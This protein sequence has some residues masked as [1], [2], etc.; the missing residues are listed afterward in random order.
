MSPVDLPSALDAAGDALKAAGESAIVL[1][2]F[3]FDDG[4]HLFT[5]RLDPPASASGAAAA[6]GS[7]PTPRLALAR[8]LEQRAEQALREAVEARVRDEVER[9]LRAEAA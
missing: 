3:R 8:A 2:Y 5:I 9:R 4:R 7:G 1:G 6:R